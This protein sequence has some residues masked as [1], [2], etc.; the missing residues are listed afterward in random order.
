MRPYHKLESRVLWL[1]IYLGSLGFPSLKASEDN[2][3]V[4]LSR[5]TGNHLFVPVRV[6][7]RPAWFAVD[8]GAALTIVDTN[9][10][11]TLGLSARS[12][13]VQLPRQIEVNDRTVPV[14]HVE[15]LELGRD[16]LG[17]GPVALIDLR[18]FRGRLRGSNN[19][20]TMDGIIGLD[21]LERYA[22]V[23]DCQNQRIYLQTAGTRSQGIGPSL[24][25]QRMNAVPMRITHSGALEVEGRIG[26]NLYSFVVDTGG[27]ETLIPFSVAVQNGI[28]VLRTTVNA[29]GIHSKEKPVGLALTPLL[30]IGKYSLGPTLVG[31]TG[32]PEGPEDLRYPFGGLIGADFFFDHH[33]VIDVGHK[34]LYFR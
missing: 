12:E 20:V 13:T 22:A 31:V 32:L 4:S 28:T 24:R 34:T 2:S 17:A 16:D 30:E 27:F 8:T 15:R 10:A 1:V 29:K 21:I 18:E 3:G 19:L 9:K 5:S 25:G 7:N 26:R 6:N 33:G 11:K 23:I 14:A